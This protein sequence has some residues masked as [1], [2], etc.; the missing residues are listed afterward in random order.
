MSITIKSYPVPST[1]ANAIQITGR[2]IFVKTAVANVDVQ[3]LGYDRT[4][5][6]DA[7]NVPQSGRFKST[8]GFI[9]VAVQF[10]A[11]GNGNVELAICDTQDEF[12]MLVVG[13]QVNA[14]TLGGSGLQETADVVAAGGALTP[15]IGVNA[16]RRSLIV[17]SLPTNNAAGARFGN[18]PAVAKG[19][20]LYPGETLTLD[21]QGAVS[22]I[23]ATA[24]DTFTIEE[25]LA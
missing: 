18:A 9:S 21:T 22:F 12:D 20:P 1:L 10:T 16:A 2:Y 6:I 23:G 19:T 15:L 4:R 17:R 7:Q 24:G 5:V 13:G 14:V 25:I 11:G 8:E 3:A